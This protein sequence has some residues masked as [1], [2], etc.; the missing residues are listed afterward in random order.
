[1]KHPQNINKH[2]KKKSYF[3]M[4]LP[5]FNIIKFNTA[6]IIYLMLAI[7]ICSNS[8]FVNTSNINLKQAHK[9]LIQKK[10]SILQ[11]E[12]DNLVGNK[13]LAKFEDIEKDYKLMKKHSYKNYTLKNANKIM[14]PKNININKINSRE[15]I[16][17]ET[18]TNSS[19]N[20]I[21]DNVYLIIKVFLII[22]FSELSSYRKHFKSLLETKNEINNYCDNNIIDKGSNI[23]NKGKKIFYLIISNII[24]L[25]IIKIL[26]KMIVYA[27]FNNKNKLKSNDN[28]SI[29]I[30]T[31]DLIK[32]IHIIYA[33]ILIY[34]S[35]FFLNNTNNK[36]FSKTEN[37]LEFNLEDTFDNNVDTNPDT[38]F[39]ANEIKLFLKC[40]LNS[41]ISISSLNIVFLLLLKYKSE[42][43][44]IIACFSAYLLSGFIFFLI[45]LIII[46]KNNQKSIMKEFYDKRYNYVDYI[47]SFLYFG[48]ACELLLKS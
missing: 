29:I 40:Y 19:N 34:I 20:Y 27:F 28:T 32:L 46:G 47:S 43:R 31:E 13:D 17:V 41:L 15:K 24:S 23:F 35:G 8:L 7:Y 1:M 22:F 5:D 12:K 9:V 4:L 14:K 25:I 39:L 21:N 18:K 42:E 3:P 2:K 37:E 6:S 16:K 26:D 38:N 11:D 30:N 44:V 45:F 10:I 33:S 48:F 36:N